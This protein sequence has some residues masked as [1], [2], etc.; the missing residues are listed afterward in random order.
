MHEKRIFMDF[1]ILARKNYASIPINGHASI[2]ISWYKEE[3]LKGY[4]KVYSL[5]IENSLHY[6]VFS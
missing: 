4:T 2:I 1:T 6:H 5:Y 3:K